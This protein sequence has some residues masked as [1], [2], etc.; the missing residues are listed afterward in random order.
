MTKA[1]FLTELARE[2][3]K[4]N[5]ADAADIMEEYEQH[6]AF[7]LAD[8]YAQEEIAAK[9]GTPAVLAAQ[10]ETAETPNRPGTGSRVLTK[11][12]L[13]LTE[14]LGG[15]LFLLLAGWGLVMAAAAVA[16]GAGAVCLL[17][18]LGLVRLSGIRKRT[19][20][21]GGSFLTRLFRY[22]CPHTPANLP[23]AALWPE[24]LS[25]RGCDRS[26]ECPAPV[27]FYPPDAGTSCDSLPCFCPLWT[28]YI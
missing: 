1:E 5:V 7:K 15:L 2:L 21:P 19:A 10:F 16:C 11:I 8:G 25:A 22:K 23:P 13:G 4:R 3:E 9:L 24:K 28:N 14:L 6:F 26:P 27:P 17:A 12:G 18:R 20:H